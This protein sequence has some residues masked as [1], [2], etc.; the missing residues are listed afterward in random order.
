[1]ADN[2][3]YYYLK[4]KENFFDSPEIKVLEA[5]QNG[6]KYSNLLLKLYLKSLRFEGMVRLNEYI[7]YSIDM[8]SAITGIDSDTVRVAFD[9]FKKLKLIEI[10]DDGTIFML[11]I[12]NFIGQ[13]STE[14]DRIRNYRKKID[15]T[16]K[17]VQGK[18][19]NVQQ[20]NDKSTPEIEKEIE[21]EKEKEKEKELQQ[22]NN[23]SNNSCSSF[24]GNLDVFKHF[25]KCGF[26]VNAMLME[27]ISADI[28]VYTA[29]WLMDAAT[30]AMN[31]GKIN[32]YKYVLGILQNWTSKGRDE[33][34]GSGAVSKNNREKSEEWTG[35]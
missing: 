17:V 33:S 8:I 30:E 10:L 29:K 13:S 23:K 6:Y 32:N 26:I 14:A 25:E 2:K 21:K 16:K 31:R 1:M 28:E 4:L 7:P 5:M 20:L 15:D 12:Q 19:T 22:D 18:C 35:L 9:I 27:Q 34:N 3:K 24:K 11:E